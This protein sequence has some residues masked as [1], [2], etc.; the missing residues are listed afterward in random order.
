MGNNDVKKLLTFAG[1]TLFL[2][3]G[4]L[5][6]ARQLGQDGDSRTGPPSFKALE[7]IAE[8]VERTCP[9]CHGNGRTACEEC[10]GRGRAFYFVV[11]G[12]IEE[13]CRKCGGSKMSECSSCKGTGKATSAQPDI[14]KWGGVNNP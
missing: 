8:G 13:T 3:L 10:G 11:G 6:L 2:L 7:P 1:G 9:R 5:W 4:G 12:A 14:L